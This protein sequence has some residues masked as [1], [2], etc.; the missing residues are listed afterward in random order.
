MKHVFILDGIVIGIAQ[1]M[2]SGVSITTGAD[3]CIVDDETQV[4]VGDLYSEGPTFTAPAPAPAETLKL[5]SMQVKRLFTATERI[6][7]KSSVDP[8]VRDFADILNDPRSTVFDMGLQSTR[9]QFD[10]LE[11][12]HIITTVRKAEI[13]SGVFN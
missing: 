12:A 5:D 2:T 4:S 6:A 3:D 1:A 9:D 11:S 8:Y 13:L 7:M 10:C